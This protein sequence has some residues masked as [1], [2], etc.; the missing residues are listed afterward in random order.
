MPKVISPKSH[1]LLIGGAGYVGSHMVRNLLNRG[2]TPVVFDNLSSGFRRFIPKGV[3]FVKGD[4]RHIPDT[5][6]VFKKFK[7]ELSFS[8]LIRSNLLNLEKRL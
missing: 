7:I 1:V 4:L 2:V 8:F 5:R 6:K 3:P